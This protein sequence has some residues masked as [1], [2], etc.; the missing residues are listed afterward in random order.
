MSFAT[1]Y[2]ANMPGAFVRCPRCNKMWGA[3]PTCP[4]PNCGWALSCTHCGRTWVPG[5]GWQDIDP[6]PT[7]SHGIC[8]TC[9]L[10]HYTAWDRPQCREL[11]ALAAARLKV[12]G[13]AIHVKSLFWHGRRVVALG[14]GDEISVRRV[15]SI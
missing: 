6:A 3:T 10:Q 2:Y 1:T 9:A 12:P 13:W 15:V 11:I 8:P 5:R 14:H 4:T 7:V